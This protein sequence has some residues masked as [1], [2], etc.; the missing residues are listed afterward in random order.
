[1]SPFNRKEEVVMPNE[2][3]ATLYVRRVP[4][5]VK[6]RFVKTVRGRGDTIQ[7][8]IETLMRMYNSNPEK[9]DTLIS[10]HPVPG[11]GT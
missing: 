9:V 5:D 10:K 8:V 2:K 6:N 1:M 7:Q 3:F 4:E 11:G